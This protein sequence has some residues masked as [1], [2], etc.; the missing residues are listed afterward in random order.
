MRGRGVSRDQPRFFALSISTATHLLSYRC[1]SFMPVNISFR[2]PALRR[3]NGSADLAVTPSNA[4]SDGS[5]LS[6]TY[7]LPALSFYSP[8][9]SSLPV[10]YTTSFTS[11][12]YVSH[13]RP[14]TSR[15]LASQVTVGGVCKTPR[16]ILVVTRLIYNFSLS[17]PARHWLVW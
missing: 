8:P 3:R 16:H 4:A 13:S 14:F 5:P 9:D 7:V 15:S 1:H 12:T 2:R 17:R 11:P 6:L 10:M